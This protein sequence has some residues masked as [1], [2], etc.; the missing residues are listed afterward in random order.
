MRQNLPLVQ[1]QDLVN[2]PGHPHV[3]ARALAG[4]ALVKLPP[5]VTGQQMLARIDVPAGPAGTH[6]SVDHYTSIGPVMIE[7]HDVLVH[8]AAGIV[9][10]G[11][12]L[13]E[14]TLHQ[15]DQTLEGWAP[16][17]DRTAWLDLADDIIRLPG[18][19][20]SLLTGSPE[21]Y[22]HWM[23]DGIGRLAATPP[24]MVA[25]CATVLHPAF[26]VGFQRDSFRRLGLDLPARPVARGTTLRVEHMVVPWSVLGEH[27]PHPSL[28]TQFAQLAANPPPA[29]AP[30]L[31]PRRLY[32]DRSTSKNR[33]LI[34]EPELIAALA[35][36]GFVPVRLE[37]L[38]L[39]V[40]IA[41]FANADV[42]VAPHGAGLTNILFCR[43]GTK[44]VEILMDAWVNWCFRRLAAL[45]GMQ[46]DC[47]IGLEDRPPDTPRA[48]W[49]HDKDWAV[50]IPHVQAA[51]A[52]CLNGP[53]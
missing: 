31:Y 15:A 9:C 25:N 30:G 34:N 51:V 43:P 33:H 11:G 7:F 21:N 42:I 8:G 48:A 10:A 12:Q 24:D 46:Y 40:Q 27:L 23:M 14:N 19:H 38:S 3:S 50:S 29:A 1:L 45:V 49:P 47:V 18:R 22:Y 26:D 2:I 39:S 4:P 13:I 52:Q 28:A 32:I 35:K 37:D 20:L 44:L 5:L 36:I 6:W 17:Q 53:G 16:L 41:L